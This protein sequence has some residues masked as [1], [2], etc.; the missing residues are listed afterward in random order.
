M[1][2][3]GWDTPWVCPVPAMVGNTF[4]EEGMEAVMYFFPNAVPA[5]KLEVDILSLRWTWGLLYFFLCMYFFAFLYH[6]YLMYSLLSQ[7]HLSN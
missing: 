5:C 4:R 2:D 3:Q 6:Y 1:S 7:V